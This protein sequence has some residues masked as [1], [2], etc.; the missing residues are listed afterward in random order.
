MNAAAPAAPATAPLALPGS[1]ARPPGSASATLATT[2]PASAAAAPVA[3][4]PERL[5]QLGELPEALRR[6]L[7]PLNPGGSIHAEQ[8]S[9]RM[10]I[11]NG[12]VFREGDMLAA[13]LRVEQIR[14]RSVVLSLRGQRFELAL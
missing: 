8:A 2:A 3:A 11:L 1:T 9:A 6:E 5:L 13:Q 7:G 14:P 4:V 10:V 12:Q